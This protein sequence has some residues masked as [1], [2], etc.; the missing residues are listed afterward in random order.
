MKKTLNKELGRLHG[1]IYGDKQNITEHFYRF[2]NEG[3]EENGDPNDISDDIIQQEPPQQQ[4]MNPQEQPPMGGSTPPEEPPQDFTN[5]TDNAPMDGAPSDMPQEP[6]MGD[7]TTEVD[8]TDL[9]NNIQD[10]QKKGDENMGMVSDAAKKIEHVLSQINNLTQQLGKMDG[11][12]GNLE[13]L[14]KQVELMRPP[15]ESERRKA[16][17]NDSYPYSI[18]IDDYK[19]GE[20]DKTQTDMEGKMSMMNSI[21]RGYNEKTIKD[22]FDLPPQNLFDLSK[23]Q[24]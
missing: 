23:H 1:I 18:T 22:S 4:D 17:T 11:I 5:P 16:L 8:I 6:P 3:D 19:K 2:F 7:D 21:L 12:I 9:V 14:S 10:L 13:Q 15:T 20:G 24:F